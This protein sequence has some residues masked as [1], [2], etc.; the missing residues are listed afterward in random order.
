MTK[1]KIKK[2]TKK[3]TKKQA[4]KVVD[5][6]LANIDQTAKHLVD[7]PPTLDKPVDHDA[8][9]D[10][11]VAKSIV[12]KPIIVEV[13]IANA[14]LATWFNTPVANTK[15]EYSKEE[16]GIKDAQF[17]AANS[18]SI[19]WR[20]VVRPTAEDLE[21]PENKYVFDGDTRAK[22]PVWARH[23]ATAFAVGLLCFMIYE[24]FFM[25]TT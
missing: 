1:P 22:L 16:S 2:T 23:S 9:F 19:P 17:I 8:V 7:S 5:K 15:F 24:M 13:P 21:L 20:V 4:K 6:Y 3:T 12:A 25:V 18:R 11:V 14:E 10:R